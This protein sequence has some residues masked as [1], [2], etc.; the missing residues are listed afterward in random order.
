MAIYICTLTQLLVAGIIP[1]VHTGH[2][3]ISEVM[4]WQNPHYLFCAKLHSLVQIKL[5]RGFSSELDK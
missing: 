4:G 1:P 2:E 5:I 3:V